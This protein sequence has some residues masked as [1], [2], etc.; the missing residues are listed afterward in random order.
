MER[1]ALPVRLVAGFNKVK[2]KGIAKK[3]LLNHNFVTSKYNRGAAARRGVER[4]TLP[5]RR[6]VERHALPVRLSA[7][8]KRYK[9]KHCEE[10]SLENPFYSFK[11][12]R[13]WSVP[14]S[15]PMHFFCLKN[16]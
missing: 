5:A 12:V 15:R 6:G 10:K 11:A 2:I 7:A 13:G 9:L 3:T 8:I 14:R 1:H 4:P 16:I